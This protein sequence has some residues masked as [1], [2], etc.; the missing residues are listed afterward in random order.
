M[1]RA[2]YIIPLQFGQQ[3]ILAAVEQQLLAVLLKPL[4]LVLG[5]E[6]R[7][8]GAEGQ[9]VDKHDHLLAVFK[10][11]LHKVKGAFQ[12]VAR[13][14]NRFLPAAHLRIERSAHRVKSVV[15]IQGAVQVPAPLFQQGQRAGAGGGFIGQQCPGSLVGVQPGAVILALGGK[16][17]SGVGV[18]LLGQCALKAA[19]LLVAG[20]RHRA[21]GR[22]GGKAGVQPCQQQADQADALVKARVHGAG[23]HRVKGLALQDILDAVVLVVLAVEHPVGRK[24]P[25]DL[26][27]A[28]ILP[29]DALVDGQIQLVR[30]L[31]EGGQILPPAGSHKLHA[32]HI[33]LDFVKV[34]G[35]QFQIGR[36]GGV[37]PVGAGVVLPDAQLRLNVDAPHAVQRDEVKF[38][39]TLVVLR[40][41]ARRHNDPA[42]RHGLVAE[43]LA[44][45]KL[46][47]RRGQRLAD[48]VDLVDEQDTVF[49]AGALHGRVDA[50]DD[51]TH[52]VLGHAAGLAAKIP[53]P[54]EGQA[55]GTLPRVVGDG[56][57]HQRNV[58]LLRNL[59]HNL[60]FAYARRAHQ[61]NGALAD[62]RYQR[63]ADIVRGKVGLHRTLDFLFGTL[64]IHGS[65]SFRVK[66]F[67][68]QNK[69]HGPGRHIGRGGAVLQKQKRNI[70]R[71]AACGIDTLAVGEV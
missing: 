62:G 8:V 7:G 17:R 47:H 51:L 25:R 11:L 2:A 38:P 46:Q 53:L 20:I 39:H 16:Q 28:Q 52:R 24:I 33:V 70:E 60:G 32:V 43:G 10:R 49:L 50:G 44:L 55:H 34:L 59:L 14:G 68:L 19:Q 36:H 4:T 61:Q 63:A 71:R 30:R 9:L 54:D 29:D 65:S 3:F 35:A 12:R 37:Q 48:A 45:Q 6:R 64:N 18:I 66:F 26:R 21:G 58:A 22:G 1:F 27:V 5:Q 31:Q 67:R 15:S 41:V 56:I 40:R 42:F 69:A 57:G 23:H 13:S